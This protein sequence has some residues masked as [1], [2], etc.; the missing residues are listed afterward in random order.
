MQKSLQK[1]APQ[2]RISHQSET[3][4]LRRT[5]AELQL[6]LLELKKNIN[7]MNKADKKVV[8]S[9]NGQHYYIPL[10]D[11]IYCAADGNYTNVCFH[12][13]TNSHEDQSRCILISKTLKSAVDLMDSDDFIRCHQSYLI[14]KKHVTG[15]NSRKG[16]WLTLSNEDSIPVSRRNKTRVLALFQIKYTNHE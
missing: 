6:E 1:Q 11:I 3:I 9:S 10:S 15:Y 13:D 2:L 16:L 14:N 5:V 12:Q 7:T 4:L 8:L